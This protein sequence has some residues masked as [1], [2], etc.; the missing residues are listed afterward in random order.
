MTANSENNDKPLTTNSNPTD[1]EDITFFFFYG[2]VKQLVLKRY[3]IGDACVLSSWLKALE[4][5]KN[6]TVRNEYIKLMTIALQYTEPI[7]PFKDPPPE[8]IDPL[9]NGVIEMARKFLK[10]EGTA[11]CIGDNEYDI[12]DT[13]PT[14]STAMSNDKCQYASYQVIPNV[15][16][17][18][19]YAF[20]DEP[21]YNWSL[22]SQITIPKSG[23]HATDIEWE[24]ALAGIKFIK[25]STDNVQVPKVRKT[26]TAK[27]E[28]NEV[29]SSVSGS[30][31][32][33]KKSDKLKESGETSDICN[34]MHINQQNRNVTE[35]F[36]WNDASLLTGEIR[37][38]A[39]MCADRKVDAQVKTQIELDKEAF[40]AYDKLY[41]GDFLINV[42]QS[43][44]NDIIPMKTNVVTE[45]GDKKTIKEEQQQQQQPPALNDGG[46]C[47]GAK[48]KQR[49]CPRPKLCT[50]RQ[51][52]GHGNV[53]PPLEDRRTVVIDKSL[54]RISELKR[55]LAAL[56]APDGRTGNYGDSRHTTAGPPA[57]RPIPADDY[58]A[59][60]SGRRVRGGDDDD[61]S[62]VGGGTARPARSAESRAERHSDSGLLFKRSELRSML[63]F[64]GECFEDASSMLRNRRTNP[65]C[66]SL[67]QLSERSA[68]R[69]GGDE[70]D[71]P[72]SDA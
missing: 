16:V 44:I 9:E 62:G 3:D 15:G 38:G 12:K 67:A 14:V 13:N 34:V 23:P 63:D 40:N 21:M 49:E 1:D 56:K 43:V 2:L 54:Q 27:D 57:R 29:I 7:C 52:A 65:K 35:V 25:P 71:E 45:A 26:A 20:S 10:K 50:L 8:I 66:V 37:L 72:P 58:R 55:K 11:T 22:S 18:C 17:Q 39:E 70:S 36:E 69:R 48:T 46:G 59:T 30:R 53:E 28:E 32:S 60:L 33:K 41:P 19:Y 24:R 42:E 47:G 5:N 64:T 31:I 68:K 51:S 61:C 6:K 4:Q